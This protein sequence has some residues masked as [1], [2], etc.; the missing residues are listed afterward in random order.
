MWN[1]RQRI[2]PEDRL[3]TGSRIDRP[4]KATCVLCKEEKHRI[5]MSR[6]RDICFNCLLKQEEENNGGNLQK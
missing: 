5:E 6:T 4:Q 2:S 1:R 3:C